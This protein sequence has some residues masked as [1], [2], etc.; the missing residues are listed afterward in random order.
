MATAKTI[1]EHL[2]IALKEIGS[3]KPGFDK[4]VNEWILSHLDYPIEYGGESSEEVIQNYPRYLREFIK[5]R[6]DG[7]LSLLTEKKPR[8]MAEK[9][10]APENQQE[11]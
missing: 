11:H 8:G 1:K 4:K 7:N 9:E 3:I 6:L 2:S 10:K 5:H